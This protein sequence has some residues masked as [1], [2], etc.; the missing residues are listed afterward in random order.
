MS[1]NL[2]GVML[3]G[4]HWFL[5]RDAFP[6]SNGR[7]LWKFL[8]DEADHL[9]RVGVDAVWI[10]P[11]S[12][13]AFGRGNSVG[14]DIYDHFDLGEFARH[15][16]PERRTK[17]GS[18]GELLDC[19]RALRGGGRRIQV[20]ADVV[21]NHKVGGGED[22]YWAAV[23][24]DKERRNWERWG[25]GFE[26]GEIDVRAYTKFDHA[27]RG[28]AHSAF[29]WG[30][31]HFD[32]V[33]TAYKIRQRGVTFDDPK[34]KYVYRFLYNE[35][36]Y[37][38]REKRFE[39]WV[40]LEKGNY[41]YLTGCDLDYGRHDVREEMKYWGEW[42][43]RELELDGVRL[44]AVKHVCADYVREWLGHVRWKSGR[45]LFAVAEYIAGDMGPLHAYIDRVSN[46]GEFPSASACSTSRS[47]SNSARP[48][49]WA[50]GS[51]SG[52]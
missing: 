52:D 36:G 35:E 6:G 28:G 15:G 29:R 33:D 16:D 7:S 18:R 24:V 34:D 8:G 50:R 51:T 30:A 22:E 23:R 11:A 38:P 2:N 31:R 41:D 10:P 48:P 27:E 3:Q 13:A 1:A 40:S 17:Y 20:Y 43:A 32:S 25:D 46:Y 12:K 14:Y 26:E 9:R 44:D 45:E 49:A 47:G 21:L 42:L 4:F 39:S 37:L 5:K 19:V